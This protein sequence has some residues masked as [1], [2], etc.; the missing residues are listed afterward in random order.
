MIGQC[1]QLVLKGLVSACNWLYDHT[2][3]T[4][5]NANILIS[6]NQFCGIKHWFFM[7]QT[8]IIVFVFC[9]FIALYC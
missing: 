5:F 1:V 4:Q 6:Q 9:F 8:C 3:A 2:F 7:V